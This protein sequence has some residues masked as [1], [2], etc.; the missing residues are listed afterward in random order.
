[1]FHPYDRFPYGIVNGRFELMFKLQGGNKK[2]AP[3]CHSLTP[4]STF[5]FTF[6]YKY[7]SRV[8]LNFFFANLPLN[9]AS[10]LNGNAHTKP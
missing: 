4:V 3:F 6:S 9:L 5:T 2:K 10:K 8:R 1:M 7:V